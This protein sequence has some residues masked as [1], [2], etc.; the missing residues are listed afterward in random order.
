MDTLKAEALKQSRWRLGE[1]GYVEKGPFPKE[2][3]AVNVSLVGAH[4][5]TGEAILSLTPRHSGESPVV[6][7][8]TTPDV[9]EADTKVEDL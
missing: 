3:T 5:E 7:V 6:Y 1:D 2:K 8:S 4:P 9:S